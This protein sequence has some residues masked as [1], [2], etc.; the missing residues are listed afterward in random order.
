MEFSFK[1]ADV[2]DRFFAASCDQAIHLEGETV[3]L[4][5]LQG[6]GA[7]ERGVTIDCT[8]IETPGLPVK[9][10]EPFQLRATWKYL[11]ASAQTLMANHFAW[12]LLFDPTVVARAIAV[13]GASDGPEEARSAV[14]RL[15]RRPGAQKVE[16][17]N[18]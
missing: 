8:P 18:N 11:A 12:Q 17:V 13:A 1:R 3:Q 6:W 16:T 9:S 10:T 2:C 4:V 14:I 15:T 5:T 7:D